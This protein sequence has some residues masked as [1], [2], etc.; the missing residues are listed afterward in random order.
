MHRRRRIAACAIPVAYFLQQRRC[1][2]ATGVTLKRS[3]KPETVGSYTQAYL[4]YETAPTKPELERER[5]RFA[6]AS[7]NTWSTRNNSYDVKEVPENMYT[8]GKEG[9]TIPISIFKDQPDPTIGPE[10]TYPGIYENKVAMK[11]REPAELFEMDRTNSYESPLQRLILE[12]HVDFSIDQHRYRMLR[13]SQRDHHKYM[14]ERKA[15]PTK[16]GKAGGSPEKGNPD[17]AKPS[18]SAGKK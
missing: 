1:F 14:D 16:G 18:A 2:G 10:C 11:V 12:K 15:G 5:R 9:M 3:G 4:P 13:M 7:G 17:K 8:Y 6:K